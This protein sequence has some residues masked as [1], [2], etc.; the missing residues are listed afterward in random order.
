MNLEC[1]Y[2]SITKCSE[3]FAAECTI[4]NEKSLPHSFLCK[5]ILQTCNKRRLL[6]IRLLYLPDY[7]Q[8]VIGFYHGL[9]YFRPIPDAVKLEAPRGC[10]AA[11]IIEDV[12]PVIF[13]P[14]IM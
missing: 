9:G 5:K 7:G 2:T 13:N 11:K 4:A 14:E 10:V 12:E 3:L 6:Q 8:G 1:D